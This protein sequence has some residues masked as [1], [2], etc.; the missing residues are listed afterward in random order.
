MVLDLGCG[1][2]GFGVLC[3]GVRGYSVQGLRF[4]VVQ[5]LRFIVVQGLRF[6]VSGSEFRVWYFVF[7]VLVFRVW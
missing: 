2:V 5:G 7:Q 6:K 3:S 1:G 4:K